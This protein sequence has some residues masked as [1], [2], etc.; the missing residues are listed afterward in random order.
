MSEPFFRPMNSGDVN[1]ALRIINDHDEDD[2]AWAQTTYAASLQGQYVLELDSRIIGVTGA[3]PIEGT[4]R[5][6]GISWTYLTREFIGRGY[7]RVLL[8]NLIDQIRREGCR[9]A[10]VNTSD[11]YDPE[12]GDIYRDAREAYRAVG[13]LEE[14]RHA[15]YYDKNEN[16]ITYA[17]RLEDRGPDHQHEMNSKQ[18]RLTDVDEIPECDGAYWLAWELD[19]EGT[20]P[21]SFNMI[22][23]QVQDWGGRVIFMAFPSD[24]EHAPEFMTRCRFRKDGSLFDYY[25]DGTD[26]IHFRYDIV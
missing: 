18:I 5:S 15:D 8:E 23:E 10:F 3:T 12:D 20:D 7:G 24:L 11:Y 16:Q 13:F 19:D 1:E 2:Y 4:D 6:Y 9:K 14:M 21:S 22:K 26:E 17:M 25:E